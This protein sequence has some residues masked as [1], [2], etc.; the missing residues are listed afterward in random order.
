VA[1]DGKSLG[2]EERVELVEERLEAGLRLGR[3]LLLR[4]LRR[5]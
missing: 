3:A 1:G 4:G 2:E 5:P